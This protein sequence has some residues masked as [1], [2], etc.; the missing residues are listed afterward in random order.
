MTDPKN[1][2]KCCP[3]ND[4]NVGKAIHSLSNRIKCLERANSDIENSL[5]E[6][7]SRAID[8]E[9]TLQQHIEEEQNRASTK[10]EEILQELNEEQTRAENA[11]LALSNKIDE[12]IETERN[13]ATNVETTISSNLTDEIEARKQAITNVINSIPNAQIQSDWNQTDSNAKDYIKNKPRTLDGKSAYELAVDNGFEGTEQEWLASLKGSQG[14]QGPQGEQGIQGVQGPAG[15]DGADGQDGAPGQDG[16]S[17]VVT[18]SKSGSTTTIYVDG[19]SIATIEDG[20]DGQDGQNG[21]NGTNGTNGQDGV[22]PHIDSTTGNWFIGTTNTGVHAQGPAGQDGS[23]ATID[24]NDLLH[25]PI[26]MRN[27][28]NNREYVEI[29]GIKWA[30]MNI[31]ATSILDVGLYFQ[32]GDTQGYTVDQVEDGQKSFTPGTH[33]YWQ[34]A[35]GSQNGDYTKY[36]PS[37][38]KTVL[39]DE[40]DAAVANWGGDWRMPTKDEVE[41]LL[42]N[43]YKRYV[44][45]YENSR[46]TVVIFTDKQDQSKTLIFPVS[47]SYSGTTLHD[48][49][50]AEYPSVHTWTSTIDYEQIP[51]GP[52]AT[53]G[54]YAAF[55]INLFAL[56]YL[57]TTSMVSSGCGNMMDR[58]SGCPVRAVLDGYSNT[59]SKVA[60]TGSYNDL[61]DKPTIPVIWSGTQAQYDLL[62][63][64]SNTIYIITSAS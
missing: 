16:H 8:V 1:L 60:I 36:I 11:E 24:T 44:T 48:A 3:T 50:N 27:Y 20:Q 6:E 64:D 32:Q 43:T 34:Y 39:D 61:T 28:E 40:D 2:N 41:S 51:D 17:P 63:P 56:C 12:N 58:S 9:N 29:G 59:A 15:Q 30:T 5:D 55:P 45:N 25:T 46:V 7:K 19:T 47:G 31:G 10:E 4:G 49:T 52:N 42:A 62:T 54:S 23:G 33:K 38:M 22:T 21:Q 26:N 35:S 14:I 53:P 13:R 57:S 37:D 18:A